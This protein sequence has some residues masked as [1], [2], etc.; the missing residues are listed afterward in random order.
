MKAVVMEVDIPAHRV[1][2]QV[3]GSGCDDDVIVV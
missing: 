3:E 2:V 1:S